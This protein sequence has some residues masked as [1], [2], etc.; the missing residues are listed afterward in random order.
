MGKLVEHRF[1]QNPKNEINVS[2]WTSGMYYVS[3]LGKNQTEK[4]I[5]K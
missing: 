1:L 5:I 4:I 3:V 2:S